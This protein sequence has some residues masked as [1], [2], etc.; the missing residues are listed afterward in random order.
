MNPWEV[1]LFFS[2]MWCKHKPKS[3]VWCSVLVSVSCGCCN[4][5]RK[6]WWLKITEIYSLTT[7]EARSLKSVPTGQNQSVG[8]VML[9][10][11]SL[12]VNCFLPLPASSGCQQSL[13]CGHIF[14]SLPPSSH[15]HLFFCLY[16]FSLCLSDKNTWE[17]TE[18][19]SGSSRVISSQDP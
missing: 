16:L 8:K 10:P 14:L 3:D 12:G 15:Y 11:E 19:P 9:P 7:L 5:L 4:K 1:R 13:A 6:T 17:C 18:G 2:S